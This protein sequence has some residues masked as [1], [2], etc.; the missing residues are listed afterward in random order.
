MIYTVCISHI[1]SYSVIY[2]REAESLTEYHMNIPVYTVP[3]S[4]LCVPHVEHCVRRVDVRRVM[5]V[6]AL[7][8]LPA[9]H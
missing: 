1:D 4:G 5:V 6:D 8:D 3:R 2:K 9:V 7:I